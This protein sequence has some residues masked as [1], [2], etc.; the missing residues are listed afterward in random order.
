[1][2][3]R[4]TAID[5]SPRRGDACV[6][7]DVQRDFLPGGALAVSAGDR[8]IAPLNRCLAEFARRGLPVFATRD[9]H[10]PDTARSR[11]PADPGRRIASPTA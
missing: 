5:L 1:M 10:P 9:W 4:R 8:V 11:P 3:E 7:V 6:V 2:T